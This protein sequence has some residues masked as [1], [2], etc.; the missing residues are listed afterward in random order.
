MIHGVNILFNNFE[1]ISISFKYCPQKWSSPKIPGL[2]VL[3]KFLLLNM[4]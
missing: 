1:K 3:Y 4:P 2:T